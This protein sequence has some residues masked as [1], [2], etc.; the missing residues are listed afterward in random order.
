MDSEHISNKQRI[1][2]K[3]LKNAIDKINSSDKVKKFEI[4]NDIKGQGVYAMHI[5]DIDAIIFFRIQN[6]SVVVSDPVED[7]DVVVQLD[8]GTF[9]NLRAGHDIDGNPVTPMIAWAH[10]QLKIV[11]KGNRNVAMDAQTYEKVYR[12]LMESANH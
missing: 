10:K 9:L 5:T 2:A 11:G 4:D 8:S 3:I 7:P 6:G 1:V 12:L